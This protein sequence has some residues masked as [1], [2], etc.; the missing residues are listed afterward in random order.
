MVKT[1]AKHTR[2]LGRKL[3]VVLMYVVLLITFKFNTKG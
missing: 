1:M 2:K 3:H